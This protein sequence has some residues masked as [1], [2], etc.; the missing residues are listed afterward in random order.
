VAVPTT[1]A[2]PTHGNYRVEGR[3]VVF[4]HDP[5]CGAALLRIDD[6]R[7]VIDRKIEL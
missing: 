2:T 3:S 1:R 7:L 6:G 5:A 4:G